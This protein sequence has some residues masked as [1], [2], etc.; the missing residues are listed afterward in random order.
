[1]DGNM[2]RR[3]GGRYGRLVLYKMDIAEIQD[4]GEHIVVDTV[5]PIQTSGYKPLS[6]QIQTLTVRS[7]DKSNKNNFYIYV[8]IISEHTYNMMPDK[9]NYHQLIV[10]SRSASIYYI[11]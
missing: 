8:Q 3:R 11:K 6:L 5:Q 2:T 10:S 1:M 4:E 7:T 9:V